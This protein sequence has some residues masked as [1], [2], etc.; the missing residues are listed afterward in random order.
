MEINGEKGP[1]EEIVEQTQEEIAAEFNSKSEGDGRGTGGSDGG[2][3]GAGGAGEDFSIPID[4]DTYGVYKEFLGEDIPDEFFK[5]EDGAVLSKTAT[6]KKLNNVIS[7]SSKS[8]LSNDSF[9][10]NYMKAKGK[11]G[12]TQEDYIKS[13]TD[14]V[15]LKD[16]D[17]K[18][19]LT[20]FYKETD[21]SEKDLEEFFKNTPKIKLDEIAEEKKKEIIKSKDDELEGVF[22]QN[23]E[24]RK[25]KVDVKNKEIQ[26]SIDQ[27]IGS[28]LVSG[29]GV[30][31]IAE[32][33]VDRFSKTIKSLLEREVVRDGGRLIE[34]S[35][36]DSFM[37]NNE[38]MKKIL[39]FMALEELGELDN[40]M[41][42]Q[43][44]KVKDREFEKIE[45]ASAFGS[46]GNASGKKNWGKF[47]GN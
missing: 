39:P 32:G 41:S 42:N 15:N 44:K 28:E 17:S 11:E 7:A 19:F 38:K 1:G 9:I 43:F 23:I 27:Y 29:R 31:K 46:G 33:D 37:S 18:E 30:I 13:L 16:M 26:A 40:Y 36:L 10:S 24:S 20:K 25:Q 6:L 47:F 35:R 34:R 45:G 5:G 4:E 22:N 8:E 12:F 14:T 21:Y 3:G 2:T